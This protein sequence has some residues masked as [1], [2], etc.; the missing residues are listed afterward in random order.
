MEDEQTHREMTLLEEI[1]Q[2]HMQWHRAVSARTLSKISQLALS[3]TT[4]RNLMEDLSTDGLLTTEGVSRG[5]VPTQKAYAIYITRMRE[6]KMESKVALPP[7]CAQ[8]VANNEE[9]LRLESLLRHVGHFLAAE[10]H[11]VCI[12]WLGSKEGHLLDWVRLSAAPGNQV[13]VVIHTLFGR[14]WSKLIKPS[15]LFP[16]DL[17]DEVQAFLCQRYRGLSI[18][19]IRE[20]IMSGE[21]QEVLGSTQSLGAVF[22]MLRN[23]FTWGDESEYKLWGQEY[24]HTWEECADSVRMLRVLHL[25]SNPE[26]LVQ[27]LLRGRQ[28]STGRISLGNE[29]RVDGLD[30]FAVVGHPFGGVS[31]KG[32]LLVFGPLWMN[33]TQILGLT[34]KTA[35]FL[36]NSL[37]KI[38]ADNRSY[39]V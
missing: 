7:S 39:K 3:A 9:V 4:I 33:Y 18:E 34:G 38:E 11:L 30:P 29:L 28:L 32:W 22:R 16:P 15:Q 1:V 10:S 27:A 14:L 17:L 23:A 37:A 2:H 36:D 6:K 21:P 20:D 13:L 24:V 8:S 31:W 5:R 26:P 12:A 35:S 25:L 19:T